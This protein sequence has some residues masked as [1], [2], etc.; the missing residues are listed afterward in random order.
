MQRPES[1]DALS[2]MKQANPLSGAL[3]GRIIN[4]CR[5]SFYGMYAWLFRAKTLKVRGRAMKIVTGSSHETFRAF[6]FFGKEPETLAWI[7]GF[8]AGNT[9]NPVLFDIGANIGIYSLYAATTLPG[10]TILSFEP[11]SQSFSS[12]CKNIAVNGF[13]NITP[14]QFAL[15]NEVGAGKLHISTMSAGAG[16]A[17]LGENYP[18]MNV[19]EGEISHQGV[20]VTSLDHLVFDLGLP[21][22][23]YIKIDVDGIEEK[24][25]AGGRRVLADERL[26]GLLVEF[27]Y[28]SETDIS[29]FRE[30]LMRSGL[31]MIGRSDWEAR[32]ASGLLSRNFIFQRV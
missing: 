12:L 26:K 4:R 7:D 23:N 32:Y 14:Y 20:F 9:A 10:A 13:T 3:L 19:P 25:L 28:Q 21:L 5:F 27:Q 2:L 11:E 16:A 8:T 1:G 17:A 29:S 15:S 22:P 24:I 6:T 30:E 18:H 31:K